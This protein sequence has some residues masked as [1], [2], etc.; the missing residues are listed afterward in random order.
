MQRTYG[1][2]GGVFLLKSQVLIHGL[3]LPVSCPPGVFLR[4]YLM[5]CW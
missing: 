5:V 3:F 4:N 1:E 2:N